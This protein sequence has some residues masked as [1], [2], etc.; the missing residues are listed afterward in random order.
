MSL[1]Q[2]MTEKEDENIKVLGGLLKE[3]GMQPWAALT[4]LKEDGFAG[5]G[6]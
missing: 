3:G 5:K 4:Q 2:A 1:I 6:H